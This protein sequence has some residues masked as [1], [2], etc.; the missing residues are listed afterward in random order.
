MQ[1]TTKKS[2]ARSRH[3]P[4]LPLCYMIG[5]LALLFASCS[6]GAQASSSQSTTNASTTPAAPANQYGIAIRDGWQVSLFTKGSTYT[7][8]DSVVDDGTNIFIDY[9]NDA[10][11]DGSDTKTSTVVEYDMNGKAL[12]TFSVPGHSDGLRMDPSTKLLW[13]ISNEDANPKMETIDPSSGTITPYTFPKTPHDGG[14]DDV[15]FM[16]GKTFIT[17]SNPT[18]DKSGANVFPALDSITLSN[19]KANLTP[20]LMGNASATDIT[21]GANNAKVTLNEVDPDSLSQDTKGNLVMMNQAGSEIVTITDPGTAQQK[22]SRLAVGS[23]LDDT[24]WATASKG[25]LLVIDATSNAAYWLRAPQFSVGTIYTQTPDDS[26]VA[27]LIATVDPGTGILTPIAL[28]FG[29]PTGMLFVPDS[30]S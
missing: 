23:Q 11:K 16:N 25:R 6:S 2:E 19:G 12:K 4:A 14:Y 7:N 26:G 27:G 20:V 9:Q 28:G 17:A 15:W 13:A 21:T 29:K 5:A 22:V 24:V 30:Q 10:A 18:L 1:S 3:I 8:P